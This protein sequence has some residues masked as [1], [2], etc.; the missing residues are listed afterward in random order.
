VEATDPDAAGALTRS[1]ASLSDTA[2]DL[3]A[4]A[5]LWRSHN[6]V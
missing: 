3:E 4:A 1:S 5:G 2:A 6:L